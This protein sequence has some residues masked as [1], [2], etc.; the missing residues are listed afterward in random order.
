MNNN[1]P[2]TIDAY[3]AAFPADVQQLLESMRA[4]IRAEAPNAEEC[5][6]YGIPTFKLKGNLVHFAAFKNHIG[7]YPGASGVAFSQEELSRF[8]S[9]KGSIQFPI[10]QPLP[11]DLVQRIVQFRVQQNLEKDAAKKLKKRVKI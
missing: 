6:G 11:L 4:T 3:I 7:F 1:A 2:T 9:A 5:I 10:G 8:K